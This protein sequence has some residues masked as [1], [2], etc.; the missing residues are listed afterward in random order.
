MNVPHGCR[1]DDNARLHPPDDDKY[2]RTVGFIIMVA[3]IMM[4]AS[5]AMNDDRV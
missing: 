3:L 2:A 5:E 4:A 1:M